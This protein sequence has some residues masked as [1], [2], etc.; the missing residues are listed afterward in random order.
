MTLYIKMDL[1]ELGFG[2]VDWNHVAEDRDRWLA[3]LNTV[4]NLRGAITYEEFV[5]YLA[6]RTV[7]FSRRT[8]LHGVI[9]IYIHSPTYKHKLNLQ[10]ESLVTKVQR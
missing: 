4:M 6:A 3:P 1:T 7:I 2:D 5:D 9:H 8:L 10:H